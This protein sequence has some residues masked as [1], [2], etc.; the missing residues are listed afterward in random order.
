M[1]KETLVLI[2]EPFFTTKGVG[3]GTGLGLAT[4]YGAVKQ[5]NGF[6]NV[7]SEPNIGST[8]SVFLPRYQGEALKSRTGSAQGPAQRGH[9][10]IL[11]VEDEPAILNVATLLLTRQGYTVLAA[12][13]P[14]LAIRLAGEH[15]GEISLLLTDV[16]MPVMNGRDLA[17]D[18]VS[19]HPDLKLLFMSGF[20]ADVIAHHGAIEDG[21]HSILKPFSVHSLSAKV[22]EV[23]DGA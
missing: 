13:S 7:C 10:T 3:K 14:G 17:R 15:G 19:R 12:D 2:F 22:R 11:L 5:N 20:T 21:V 18:L 8:F 1:D 6:I 23:L 4:V 9:E 16:V